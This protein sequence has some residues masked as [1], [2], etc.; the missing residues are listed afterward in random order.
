MNHYFKRYALVQITTQQL[1]GQDKMTGTC[2]GGG[3]ELPVTGAC[4]IPRRIGL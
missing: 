4:S 3:I 2:S 1:L